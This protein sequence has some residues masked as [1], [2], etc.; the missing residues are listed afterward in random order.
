MKLWSLSTTCSSLPE[1]EDGEFGYL[2]MVFNV[3]FQNPVT[4]WMP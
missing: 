1:T 3:V 2:L 4:L